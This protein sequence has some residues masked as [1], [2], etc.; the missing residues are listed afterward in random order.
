MPTLVLGA[1]DDWLIPNLHCD[2][3]AEIIPGAR[4]ERVPGTGHGLIMQEPDK[5]AEAI[6]GFIGEV[7]R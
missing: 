2:R 3:W 5:T 1:E 6:L 4:L 7:N